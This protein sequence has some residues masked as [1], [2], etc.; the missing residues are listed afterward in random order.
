[1]FSRKSSKRTAW[2]TPSTSAGSRGGAGTEDSVMSASFPDTS[3]HLDA[4]DS[5][6]RSR[7]PKTSVGS[8]YERRRALKSARLQA[9]AEHLG[10]ALGSRAELEKGRPRIRVLAIGVDAPALELEETHAVEEI[11]IGRLRREAGEQGLYVASVEGLGE[12]LDDAHGPPPQAA[13][14][15]RML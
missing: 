11:A 7:R 3:Y 1:M 9:A 5:A 15:I 2:I 6:P 14:L 12:A 10:D 8:W 13:T 4:G